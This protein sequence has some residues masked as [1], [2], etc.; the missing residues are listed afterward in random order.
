[1]ERLQH[2]RRAKV[3]KNSEIECFEHS[4]AIKRPDGIESQLKA[5]I[6]SPRELVFL[7]EATLVSSLH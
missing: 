6:G 7:G 4:D 3:L 5:I 2:I 1:M